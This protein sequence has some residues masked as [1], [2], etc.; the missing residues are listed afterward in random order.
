VKALQHLLNVV[1][2]ASDPE[3]GTLDDATRA[4]IEKARG[5][6]PGLQDVTKEAGSAQW[7]TPKFFTELRKE[8]ARRQSQQNESQPK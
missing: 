2:G 1:L 7:V 3:N 6:I 4:N 8:A 5:V